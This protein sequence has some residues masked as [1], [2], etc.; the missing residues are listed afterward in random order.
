MIRRA[1]LV[2][3][4]SLL[5][6]GCSLVPSAPTDPVSLHVLDVRPVVAAAPRRDLVLAIS[7]PQAAPG[8]DSTDMIYVQKAHALDRFATHRWADTPARML[9]PLLTR[10]LEDT[11]SFRAVVQASSGLPADLR[12]D[13]EIVRLR[14][15][16]LARPSRAEFALRTQLVSVP[17]RRVLAT[18]YVEVV[19]EAPSEDAAGGVTAANAAVE[20]ALAQVAAFCVEASTAARP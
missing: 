5:G 16:F 3:A 8:V 20:R 15:S 9:Y 13:T 11:G 1:V 19:Q 7:A 14:Q 2:L 12:L 10:T 17:G 18:R 6:S 4:G